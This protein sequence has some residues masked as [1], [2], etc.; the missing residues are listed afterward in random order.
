MNKVRNSLYRGEGKMETKYFDYE[1]RDFRIAGVGVDA[2]SPKHY[3]EL[4]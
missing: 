2:F 4:S 3:H 1:T